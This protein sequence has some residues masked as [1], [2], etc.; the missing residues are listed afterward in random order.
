MTA[1]TVTAQGSV[2]SSLVGGTA[3]TYEATCVE[4]GHMQ[5]CF[6]NEKTTFPPLW[7]VLKC[8]ASPSWSWP[9]IRATAAARAG[10]SAVCFV[11][12]PNLS[13]SLPCMLTTTGALAAL[14]MHDVALSHIRNKPEADTYMRGSV[15]RYRRPASR[16]QVGRRSPALGA[17]ALVSA[18]QRRKWK[19][20][21]GDKTRAHTTSR[22]RYQDVGLVGWPVVGRRQPQKTVK[23][24]SL[25]PPC[26]PT[27]MRTGKGCNTAAL[28]P[29]NGSFRSDGVGAWCRRCG[30]R[31]K[32]EG[33]HLFPRACPSLVGPPRP[34][35]L[36]DEFWGHSPRR[37]EPILCRD[38]R[39]RH[40]RYGKTITSEVPLLFSRLAGT[41]LL[42][43]NFKPKP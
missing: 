13:Y 25:T 19:I 36:R 23:R 17:E 41:V 9:G 30:R 29:V 22:N 26:R 38:F 32:K 27:F 3:A 43:Y 6:Y 12:C 7:S 5:S 15:G 1:V 24:R 16:L 39:T 2:A 14:H 34:F 18:I 8:P 28:L 40:K 33:V 4:R 37:L 31:V 11:Q 42:L 35:S 20:E 21:N 10:W